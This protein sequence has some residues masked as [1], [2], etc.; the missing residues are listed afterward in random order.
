MTSFDWLDFS[1]LK[2]IDE[3]FHEI[4]NGSLFIDETRRDALCSALRRRVEMLAEIVN[5]RVTL[6]PVDDLSK[7][8]SENTA[9]SGTDE[10][11]EDWER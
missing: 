3:E 9:Y 10:E 5:S 1:A 11:D 2:D 7:D 8:V 6:F 4:L